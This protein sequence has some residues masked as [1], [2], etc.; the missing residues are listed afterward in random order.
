[1]RLSWRDEFP[2]WPPLSSKVLLVHSKICQNPAFIGFCFD[3]SSPMRH[4][5]P[6]QRSSCFRVMIKTVFAFGVFQSFAWAD[7]RR[8]KIPTIMQILEHFLQNLVCKVLKYPQDSLWCKKGGSFVTIIGS[9]KMLLC[10]RKYYYIFALH[11][12]RPLSIFVF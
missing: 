7:Y 6:P 9:I 3:G 8:Q 4:T 12:V 11:L 10:W 1:M 2:C 5:L